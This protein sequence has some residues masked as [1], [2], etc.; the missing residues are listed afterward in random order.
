M[1]CSSSDRTAGVIA[2]KDSPFSR[3]FSVMEL[4]ASFPEGLSLAE[5]S[6]L[7]DLPKATVHRILSGLI[8]EGFLSGSSRV[9]V[10]VGD[11]LTRLMH[12]S[13][14][15]AWIATLTRPHLDVLT[16]K[17]GETTYL[18]RLIGCRV[19]IVASASPELQWRGYVRPEIEMAPHASASAKA[20]L[21]F[22]DDRIVAA[23]LTEDLPRFTPHTV[24]DHAVIR[25]GYATVR[26]L[27]FATCVSEM[28]EGLAALAVPIVTEGGE[29]YYSL[30]V[31]GPAQ[32]IKASGFDD[33]VA[34]LRE[35]AATLGRRLSFGR[36]A[37][38]GPVDTSAR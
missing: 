32:R 4:V 12:C 7:T 18:C 38:R 37:S 26:A 8:K 2:M 1:T 6:N 31:L 21:A 9:A 24:V 29:V 23:A 15:D 34:A 28:D 3:Y 14:D 20:I 10:R 27:G 30:G 33:R 17:L 5:I 36:A 35:V 19:R 22:Q 11:R 25:E 16:A 13:A